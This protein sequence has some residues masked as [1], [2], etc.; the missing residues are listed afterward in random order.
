MGVLDL[1][2][3]LLVCATTIVCFIIRASRGA[4]VEA[5]EAQIEMLRTTCNETSES[6]KALSRVVAANAVT[7]ERVAKTVT[8]KALTGVSGRG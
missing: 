1:C 8:G 5:L 7:L 3:V 6:N 4:E 2:G